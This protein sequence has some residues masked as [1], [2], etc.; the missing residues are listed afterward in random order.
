MF[1]AYSLNQ[2]V[3]ADGIVPFNNVVIDKGCAENLSGVGTIELNKCGVYKVT[4]DGVAAE[5]TTLQLL[6]EGVA[7][8]Q[9]QTTGTTLAFTTFIQVPKNNCNCNICSS[10]VTLQVKNSTATTLNNVNITVDKQQ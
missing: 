3:S 10:P 5:S 7:L 2:A 9:A 1:Q 4:V 6:R 8:P